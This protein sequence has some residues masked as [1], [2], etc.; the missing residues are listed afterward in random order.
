[1]LSLAP[2]ASALRQRRD[3]EA[4]LLAGDPQLPP[5]STIRRH[6]NFKARRAASRLAIAFA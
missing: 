6:C 5:K 4:A 3:R 1:M 2:I